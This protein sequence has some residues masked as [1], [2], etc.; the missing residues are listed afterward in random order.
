V[1]AILLQV[2]NVVKLAPQHAVGLLASVLPLDW[3]D[4]KQ[5]VWAPGS[6]AQVVE[7]KQPSEQWIAMLWDYICTA[8]E[9]SAN[10]TASVNAYANGNGVAAAPN[11]KEAQEVCVHV[12]FKLLQCIC[13][14]HCR[15]V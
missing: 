1:L 15:V 5:V 2:T 9:D 10:T 4:L 6:D 8:G 13:L 12:Y 7:P 3:A 14:I 11:R